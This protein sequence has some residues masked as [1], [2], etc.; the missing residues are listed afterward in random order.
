MIND[1]IVASMYTP[2]YKHYARDLKGDLDRLGI[3]YEIERYEDTGSY[4]SNHLLKPAHMQKM[5]RESG[6]DILWVDVDSR[7]HGTFDYLD[8]E[9]TGDVGAVM[10]ERNAYG[11]KHARK[12]IPYATMCTA[13]MYLRATE[14]VRSL[15]DEWVATLSPREDA[16]SIIQYDW[17]LLFREKAEGYGVTFEELPFE[18][19][20]VESG[21]AEH[22]KQMKTISPIIEQFY[23][24]VV[25]RK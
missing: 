9:F 22:N 25:M 21:D 10:F 5:L 20:W 18:Y 12:H 1:Y 17:N 15:I 3:P 4:V 11:V 13:T 2:R 7:V 24:N 6:K 19:C 14:G 23:A 16:V 8:N